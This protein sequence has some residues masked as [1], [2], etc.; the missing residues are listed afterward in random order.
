VLLRPERA[1]EPLDGRR[2]SVPGAHER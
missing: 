2:P 1:A